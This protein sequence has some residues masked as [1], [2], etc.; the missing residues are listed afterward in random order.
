VGEAC[1]LGGQWRRSLTK[2]HPLPSVPPPL[3]VGGPATRGPL[4][5]LLHSPVVRLQARGESASDHEGRQGY[6]ENACD[7]LRVVHPRFVEPGYFARRSLLELVWTLKPK[8]AVKATRTTECRRA[9]NG[10]SCG[11]TH[12]ASTQQPHDLR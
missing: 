10:H 6:G 12:A 7:D 9:S 5:R 3:T 2:R 4:G 11:P 8:I 1:N